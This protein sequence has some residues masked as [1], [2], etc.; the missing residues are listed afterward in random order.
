MMNQRWFV[1]VGSI[2]EATAVVERRERAGWRVVTREVVDHGGDWIDPRWSA[3]VGP[4]LRVFM[5]RREVTLGRRILQ[6]A[7][8]AAARFWLAELQFRGT[9]SAMP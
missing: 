5:E 6:R 7:L 4:F 1:F 2:D 9:P 8:G 3:R